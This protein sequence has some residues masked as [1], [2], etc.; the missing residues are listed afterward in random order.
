[1][2]NTLI[3]F[4]VGFY[5][6]IKGANLLISGA[7]SIARFFNISQWAIGIII[8]GIGTSIPELAIN[9]AGVFNGTEV[10]LGTVIGSNTF[11][12]LFILGLSALI[13]P[14]LIKREWVSRDFTFNIFAIAIAGV[15]IYLPILGDRTFVGISRSEGIFLL[16]LFLT[17]ATYIGTRKTELIKKV[18]YRAFAFFTSTVMVATGL[19]GVFFGGRWIVSGAELIAQSIGISDYLIGLTIVGIGTSIPELT[20][21]LVAAFRKNAGI[22][23]GNIIGS[24]IFDFLGILG[25][26]A[27]LRPLT[28]AGDVQFDILV[29]FASAVLLLVAVFI[30]RRNVLKRWE[31]AVFLLLY[32]LYLIVLLVR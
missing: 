30:G 12:I 10:G 26:V 6:L 25:I 29:T 27:T 17:W 19:I 16:I 11:N 21:S 31:G 14:L 13:S 28:V 1:M 3:L 4:V 24:N 9:I 23:I 2:L 20:V 22:A 8:V 15:M 32:F 5:I 7:S 18:D